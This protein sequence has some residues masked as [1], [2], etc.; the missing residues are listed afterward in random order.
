MTRSADALHSLKARLRSVRWIGGGS[1]AGKSLVANRIAAAHG[2]RVYGTDE[3]LR[4]HARRCGPSDAP[5][6]HAFRSMDMDERWVNRTP[7]VMFETF[8]WFHGEGRLAD[9]NCGVS[10]GSLR[11]SRFIVVPVRDQ[12]S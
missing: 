3:A 1:G 11:G 7:E 6:L 2:L 5:L 8:P 9:S 10:A 12:R 4:D